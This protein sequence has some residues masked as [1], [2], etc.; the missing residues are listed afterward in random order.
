MNRFAVIRII[1]KIPRTVK[2]QAGRAGAATK[3]KLYGLEW[4]WWQL[5]AWLCGVRGE[6]G[7][8]D[9]VKFVDDKGDK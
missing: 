8:L 7:H 1:G 2:D 4:K 3:F 6:R 9:G 5:R